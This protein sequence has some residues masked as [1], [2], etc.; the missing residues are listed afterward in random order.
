MRQPAWAVCLV[1]IVGPVVGAAEPY[2]LDLAYSAKKAALYD[3]PALSPDGQALAY[4]V[5]TPQ[6]VPE[7]VRRLD[8]GLPTSVI[9]NRIHVV[10]R[11][12]KT[13]VPL[14]PTTCFGPAWSPDGQ[15]L[16]FYALDDDAV[17]LW[18]YHRTTGKAARVSP[19][20]LWPEANQPPLWLPDGTQVIVPDRPVRKLTKPKDADAPIDADAV[21]VVVHANGAEAKAVPEAQPVSI[22]TQYEQMPTIDIAAITL[23]TGV[24]RVIVKADS[25]AQPVGYRLSP[26]GKWLSVCSTFRD[27]EEP[28][29]LLADLHIVNVATGKIVASDKD[30]PIAVEGSFDPV[31]LPHW[32]H[33]TADRLIFLDAEGLAQRD[34]RGKIKPAQPIELP[35]DAELDANNFPQHSAFTRNGAGVLVGTQP[36]DDAEAIELVGLA[37]VLLDGAVKPIELPAGLRIGSLILA[38][39]G[40]LWQPAERFAHALGRD[41]KGT[42]VRVDIDLQAGT[43]RIVGPAPGW[44]E[45]FR[46]SADHQTLVALFQNTTTP[47]NFAPVLANF[48][49]GPAWTT[50]EPRLAA[51]RLGRVEQFETTVPGHDGKPRAVRTAV[52]LP[53]DATLGSPPPALVTFYGG[54]DYSR[55]AEEFGGGDVSTIPAAVFTTR[56]YAVVY[57]DS[58]LGPEGQPGEPLKEFQATI[59]PQLEQAISKKLIDRHRI[60]LTGQSYGGYGTALLVSA[61]DLFK[62]A[63][64]V[65]GVYD[66]AG[67]YSWLNTDGDFNIYWSEK[68]QGRMGKTVWEDTARYLA[69]SP[70]FRA[71][72]IHTPLLIIHGGADTTCPVEDARKFFNALRRL[73][74]N[75]QYAEYQ[76]AGHV[77]SDWSPAN[78]R[79]LMKRVLAFL[80]RHLGKK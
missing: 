5:L 70:Y 35:D 13:D 79:D 12:Q 18:V 71:D 27:G 60:G 8:N 48:Q 65:A 63:I 15:R 52:L 19:V 32:W 53:A 29:D 22:G 66:L 26:S 75:V 51:L 74:R 3:A 40:L 1:L 39:P 2:P 9:G 67:T 4:V 41:V 72:K 54:S 44:Y 16:A 36:G 7:E 73:D 55:Y 11:G 46:A 47:P 30:I 80:E 64:P 33:P 77:P 17:R 76:N 20:P 78:H 24:A 23:A 57:V 56:G 25:P 61:T 28:G 14:A 10:D 6:R 45:A 59:L 69:N 37:L 50:I 38:R 49:P 43:A 58:P 21:E 31:S 62:A 34:C 68:G 42:S